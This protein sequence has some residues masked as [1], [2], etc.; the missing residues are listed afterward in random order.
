M[1]EKLNEGWNEESIEKCEE[2]FKDNNSNSS[3]TTEE[4]HENFDEHISNDKNENVNDKKWNKQL[5]KYLWASTV[6]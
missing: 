5:L 3:N 6:E 2:N 1:L 4:Y